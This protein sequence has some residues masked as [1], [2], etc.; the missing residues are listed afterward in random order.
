MVSARRWQCLR[1]A[2]GDS[3]PGGAGQLG[4]VAGERVLLVVGEAVLGG[5]GGVEV[6]G[7][8]VAVGQGVAD[9]GELTQRVPAACGGAGLAGTGAAVVAE[10]VVGFGGVAVALFEGG[11][12]AGDGGGG[13]GDQ[14]VELAARFG[15]FGQLRDGGGVDGCGLQLVEMTLGRSH[16]NHSTHG[17]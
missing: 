11:D 10:Q 12:P 16:E 6:F 1:N 2:S 14:G 4:V 9:V 15:Q 3:V 13:V 17:V 5:C 8:D 7:G